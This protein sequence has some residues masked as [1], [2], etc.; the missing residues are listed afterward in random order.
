[1]TATA[2]DILTGSALAYA[3]SQVTLAYSE[4]SKTIIPAIAKLEE[5]VSWSPIWGRNA[6][7]KQVIPLASAARD[8][9]AS[10]SGT[11]KEFVSN[12]TIEGKAV[13]VYRVELLIKTMASRLEGM[14]A[15]YDLAKSGRVD[16]VILTTF[17]KMIL[18]ATALAARLYQLGRD[19]TKVIIQ[20]LQSTVKIT[21]KTAEW[22]EYIPYII[23]AAFVLPP[24]LRTWGSKDRLSTAATEIDSSRQ[25]AG[26]G[27]LALTRR[28]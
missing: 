13:E 15:A 5:T 12:G 8:G 16:Q 23:V 21:G 10:I 6:Y 2:N 9:Y 4:Y 27:I 28:R 17:E 11:V 7:E 24:I 14:K 26:R 20:L 3:K 19:A 18:S 25:S 22:L 1:M